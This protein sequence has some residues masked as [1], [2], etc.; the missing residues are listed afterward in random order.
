MSVRLKVF[1]SEKGERS[2]GPGSEGVAAVQLLPVTGESAENM[3][4]FRWTP[5]GR[6]DFATI[7]EAAAAGFEV[8]MT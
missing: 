8:G 4:F 7:N 6:I 2:S 3:T 5:S 1:C